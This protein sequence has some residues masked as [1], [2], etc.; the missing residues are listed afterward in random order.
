[1][2]RLGI[3]QFKNTVTGT[4]WNVKRVSIGEFFGTNVAGEKSHHRV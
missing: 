1:M 3:A 2:K 4:S